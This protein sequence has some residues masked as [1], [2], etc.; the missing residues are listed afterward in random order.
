MQ[1]K[2]SWHKVGGQ[3]VCRWVEAEK[4][5]ERTAVCVPYDGSDQTNQPDRAAGVAATELGVGQAA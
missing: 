1:L 5:E 3:L 4:L 2:M